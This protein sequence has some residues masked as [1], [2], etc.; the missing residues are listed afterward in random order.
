LQQ[1]KQDIEDAV[2]GVIMGIELL[3]VT[4]ENLAMTMQ[5]L[6]GFLNITDEMI[7][8]KIQTSKLIF[9]LSLNDFLLIL[10]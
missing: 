8:C 7:A 3:E 5:E 1:T 9:S 2:D 4:M 10:I 6:E